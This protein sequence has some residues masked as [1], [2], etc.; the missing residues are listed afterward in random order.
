M[1]FRGLVIHYFTNAMQIFIFLMDVCLV[2]FLAAFCTVIAHNRAHTVLSFRFYLLLP[3][4]LFHLSAF[5]LLWASFGHLLCHMCVYGMITISYA[6]RMFSRGTRQ[7]RKALKQFD[8]RPSLLMSAL[9]RN[10]RHF[11]VLFIVDAFFGHCFLVYMAGHLPFTAYYSMQ[12]LLGQAYNRLFNIIILEIF[13]E[14]ILGALLVHISLVYLSSYAHQNGK[15]LLAFVGS[16]SLKIEEKSVRK[17]LSRKIKLTSHINRLV[18]HRKY[19]VHLGGVLI[20]LL[21]L[22]KI[23]NL[24]LTPFLIPIAQLF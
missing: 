15:I 1:I 16:R 14:T 3:V 12:M 9:R 8:R 23:N 20:F 7:V 2:Y 6:L 5:L 21:V 11:R 18:V 17:Q 22:F 24:H 19:G 4:L 10:L 13:G